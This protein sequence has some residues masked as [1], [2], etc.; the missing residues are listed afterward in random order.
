MATDTNA[1]KDTS[2]GSK[3]VYNTSNHSSQYDK[4]N[5]VIDGTISIMWQDTWYCH[6]HAKNMPL[7]CH[8]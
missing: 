3:K 4:C 2:A 1:I 6:V 7:E 8:I 5:T